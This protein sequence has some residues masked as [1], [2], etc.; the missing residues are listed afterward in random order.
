M[1]FLDSRTAILAGPDAQASTVPF[2]TNASGTLGRPRSM[3]PWWSA[4]SDAVG[5]PRARGGGGW[6]PGATQGCGPATEV[7]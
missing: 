6:L 4:P 5:W 1:P 7:V 3:F 2:P